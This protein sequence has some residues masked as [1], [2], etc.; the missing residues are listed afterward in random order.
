MGVPG[1]TD[2]ACLPSRCHDGG[3]GDITPGGCGGGKHHDDHDD[4]HDDHDDDHN[5]FDDH[6][7]ITPGGCRGGSHNP[8]GDQDYPWAIF[9]LFFLKY[10]R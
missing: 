6:H 4:V 8:E 2:S 1:S 10:W 5:D 7:D 3:E 9:F